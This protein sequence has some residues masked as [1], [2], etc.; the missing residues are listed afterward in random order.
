MLAN[1]YLKAPAFLQNVALSIYGAKT[2]RERFGG[3]IPEDYI[4]LS[5]SFSTPTEAEYEKQSRRLY[6]LLHSPQK[7]T[8]I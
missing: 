2:Y 7:M 1:L 4:H 5:P 3:N 8:S 6:L